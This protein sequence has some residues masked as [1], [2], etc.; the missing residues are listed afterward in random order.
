MH[1]PGVVQINDDDDMFFFFIVF[2]GT[3]TKIVCAKPFR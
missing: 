3:K 1:K 2:N